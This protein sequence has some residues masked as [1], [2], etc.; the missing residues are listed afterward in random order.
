[1]VS[2][3]VRGPNLNETLYL[4]WGQRNKKPTFEVGFLFLQQQ[5]D[6]VADACRV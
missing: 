2:E 5:T 1:M 4:I 3:S 6:Q